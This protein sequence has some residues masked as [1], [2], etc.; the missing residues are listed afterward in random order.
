M[1]ASPPD[2]LRYLKESRELVLTYGDRRVVLS[3]E[4]L[5][6]HS[7]S[8]EVQGHDGRGGS[9]P[10]HKQDVG[11]TAIEPVGNYAVKIRFSDGHDTGLYSWDW[12]SEL[13]QHKD[14]L[15]ALYQEKL[16]EQPSPVANGK[17]GGQ[18]EKF[19]PRK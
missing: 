19:F 10:R 8:A 18:V 17:P 15:W 6:V 7:P 14:S 2:E 13:C 9:L 16:A 5:R 3:A 12:L 4:F 1:N 11:I